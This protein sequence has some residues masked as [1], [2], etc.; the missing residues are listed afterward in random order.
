[1]IRLVEAAVRLC[2]CLL[3]LHN[4]TIGMICSTLR[5]WRATADLKI[6]FSLLKIIATLLLIEVDLRKVGQK[7]VKVGRWDKGSKRGTVPPK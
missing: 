5:T 7:G 2:W 4:M 3:T 6:T 1:M